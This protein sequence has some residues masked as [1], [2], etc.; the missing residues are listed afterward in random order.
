M[1]VL[2]ID[3]IKNV[4]DRPG[5]EYVRPEDMAPAHADAAARTFVIGMK[6]LLQ[7]I[8]PALQLSNR[9]RNALQRNDVTRV[10]DIMRL[11]RMDV[12]GLVRAG[13]LVRKEVCDR[14][15]DILGIDL[16]NWRPNP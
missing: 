12:L 9:A 10:I 16:P 11:S 2:I 3:H 15:R 1:A 6:R 13:S 8:D 5:V 14:M 4:E 7:P